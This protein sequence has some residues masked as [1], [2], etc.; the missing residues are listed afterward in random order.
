MVTALW[1]L[2][3]GCH[4]AKTSLGSNVEPKLRKIKYT[5]DLKSNRV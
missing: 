2:K 1:R 5:K 3:Q 4:E